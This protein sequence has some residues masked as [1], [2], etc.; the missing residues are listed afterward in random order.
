MEKYETIRKLHGSRKINFT[1]EFLNALQSNRCVL[2]QKEFYEKSDF[3]L[4]MKY[5]ELVTSN[6]VREKWHRQKTPE[7]FYLPKSTNKQL[8]LNASQY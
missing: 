7:F 4:V 2:R 5:E 8:S 1:P 3:R 6:T